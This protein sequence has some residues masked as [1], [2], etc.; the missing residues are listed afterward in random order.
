MSF[1]FCYISIIFYFLQSYTIFSLYKKNQC[2]KHVVPL[3]RSF[4]N[5]PIAALSFRCKSL[6]VSTQ[7]QQ[8]RELNLKVRK[9]I[10]NWSMIMK[11]QAFLKNKSKRHK[12]GHDACPIGVRCLLKWGTLLAPSGHVSCKN[13]NKN[14]NRMNTLVMDMQNTLSMMT[15]RW[16]L[17]GI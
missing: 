4:K 10:P 13:S 5:T 7:S 15:C 6:R 9:L 17:S 3:I 11:R 2:K 8:V 12:N 14:F 1:S 16:N